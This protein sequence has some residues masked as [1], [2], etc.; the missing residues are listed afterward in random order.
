MLS[1]IDHNPRTKRNHNPI[2]KRFFHVLRSG[3]PID[4]FK[5]PFLRYNQCARRALPVNTCYVVL[6][7]LAISLCAPL[8]FVAANP[9]VHVSVPLSPV[10]PNQPVNIEFWTD[11][12]E[13]GTFQMDITKPPLLAIFWQYGPVPIS[14]G[15][16]N[17]V[18]APGFSDP[19]TY[20][21]S[22]SASITGGGTIYA[23]TTFEVV[24][25]GAPPGGAPPGPG[26]DYH[27]EVSPPMEEV[28]KGG[29]AHY[30]VHVIYSNPSFSGTMINIHVTGLGPGMQWHPE[31][32][33]SFSIST[34]HETP[35]GTY[36]MEVEGEAQGVVRQTSFTLVVREGPE[37]HP[38]EPPPE[39]PPPEEH[40]PPPPEE[41][42]PEEHEPPPPEEHEP[43]PEY[44]PEQPPG[45]EY[46]RWEE[47]PR[48][49]APS[50]LE[51][52]LILIIAALV[53]I[54][55]ILLV[56][57]L[58]RPTQKSPSTKYCS[59]CGKPLK[60]GDAFCSSC[61]ERV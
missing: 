43:P 61:G 4:L 53:V 48:E 14:G 52:P 47:Q 19:G 24:A 60:P 17:S 25:G 22:A 29:T 18:T 51:N 1:D 58:R 8:A 40:E 50:F 30:Q 36:T 5:D 57:A 55:G 54:V 27:L 13:D 21:V 7:M 26:F 16:L 32:G 33:G 34:S 3:F 45:D 6:F 20:V 39:E 42:P 11:F 41:P 46:G 9:G 56:V 2:L 44:Q 15:L 59:K 28:E 31:P 23:S 38:P 10:A 12:G 49:P 37:D 35:P